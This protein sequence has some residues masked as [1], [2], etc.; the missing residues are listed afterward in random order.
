[1]NDY[2]LLNYLIILQDNKIIL[3]K[4]KIKTNLEIT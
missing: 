1:M 3:Y 2:G 4:S